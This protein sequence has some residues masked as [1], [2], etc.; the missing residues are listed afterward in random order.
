MHMQN[1]IKFHRLVHKILSGNQIL[2]ITKGN[3]CVVNL[4][5]WTR[6]NPNFDLGKVNAF[7]KFDWIPFTGSQDIELK[8][9]SD[10]DQ[11]PWLC[12]KKFEKM[13]AYQSQLKCSQCHWICKIC[14]NS[15]NSFSRYWAETN[16]EWQNHG[17]P[18]NS[19]PRTLPPPSPHPHHPPQSHT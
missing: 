1:L 6:K 19:I 12:Y 15:T 16:S 3:N 8:W 2:M 7:A 13:D 18:E 11:G 10:T 4:K 14:F 17:Q 9:N 5:K